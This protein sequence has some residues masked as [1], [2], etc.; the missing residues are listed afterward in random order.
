M[1]ESE[2]AI[3]YLN[4]EQYAVYSCIAYFDVFAHPVTCEEICTN[5]DVKVTKSEIR[6][7]LEDLTGL[8]L[9]F[10]SRGFYS[11]EKESD[12][13]IR[14]RCDSEKRFLL[15]QKKIRRFASLIARFPYVEAVC[16]SG[17]CSKGLIE[18]K[19]DVDYF[20]ITAPGK[21]WLCRTL[22]IAFKK[23]FLLNSKKYFCVNYFVD[24]DTLEIPDR[25]RFVANEIKTLIP[26]S[27]RPLFERFLKAN[28]WSSGFL[29][30][31]TGYNPSFLLDRKP[32]KYFSGLIEFLFNNRL[33][34]KLDDWCYDITFSTWRRRFAQLH[35]DEFNLN[36]RSKKN[37]S[38]HHP[39][40]FQNRVLSELKKRLDKVK[41]Q[42]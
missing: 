3:I 9:I 38:K 32:R 20:V 8:G 18:E 16:I 15:W 30:N 11:L 14:K 7:I 28:E 25:N 13:M 5:A 6:I 41:V 39:R 21:L 37:V 1:I 22:L 4:R 23:T 34:D 33:G 29:P 31:K 12:R 42:D 19:G 24:T 40:G 35:T 10:M 2:A 27:N 17:S 36:F 26:V